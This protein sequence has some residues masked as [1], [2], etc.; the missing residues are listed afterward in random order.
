MSAIQVDSTVELVKDE[1]ISEVNTYYTTFIDV[2]QVEGYSFQI[3]WD[4]YTGK[5]TDNIKGEILIQAANNMSIVD[6]N[7][8]TVEGSIQEIGETIGTHLYDVTKF[9]YRYMRLRITITKGSANFNVYFNS[10]SRRN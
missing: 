2:Q 5:I 10:R 8:V 9:N 7:P 4:L 1:V 6:K 3:D